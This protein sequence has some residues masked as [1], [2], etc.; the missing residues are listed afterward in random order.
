MIIYMVSK[1]LRVGVSH[2]IHTHPHTHA[3][4]RG[5]ERS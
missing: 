2:T 1:T 3:S 5:L 4:G